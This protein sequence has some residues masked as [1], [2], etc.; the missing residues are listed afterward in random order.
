MDKRILPSATAELQEGFNVLSHREHC[1]LNFEQQIS[2]HA[3]TYIVALKEF[4]VG[5]DCRKR[6]TH[7]VGYR[8]CHPADCRHPLCFYQLALCAP[9]RLASQ[10]QTKALIKHEDIAAV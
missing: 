2:P 6:V 4:G 9:L 10:I 7:I 1:F 8:T 3:R 5:I